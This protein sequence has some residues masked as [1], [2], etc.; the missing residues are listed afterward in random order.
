MEN[1]FN[2]NYNSKLDKLE[3]I[4]E[5]EK[6][7]IFRT[8]KRNKLISFV[9]ASFIILSIIDFYMIFSFIKILEIM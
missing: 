7:N 5:K 3:I 4:K 6:Y 1:V 8:V 2:I 9:L